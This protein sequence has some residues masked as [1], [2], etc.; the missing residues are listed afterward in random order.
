M[1]T[2]II[3]PLREIV[4]RE[5]PDMTLLQG[6]GVLSKNTSTWKEQESNTDSEVH[7]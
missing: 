3:D 2:Y 7:R 5:L 6:F 1:I 4:V